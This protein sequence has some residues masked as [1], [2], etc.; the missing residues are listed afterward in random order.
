MN[1]WR[2]DTAVA[3]II[4]NR[5]DTTEKV[6][7]EIA[8]AKPSKLFVIGDGPRI[9]KP[10][11][12]NKVFAA[13][14]ITKSVDWECAVFTNFSDIN[15]GCK[16][17]VV[18]GL[19][20]VFDNVDRAIILE[21]DM[22]PHQSF[23]QYCDELLD[24]YSND[25]RIGLITGTNFIPFNHNL[26]PYSYTFT[27]FSNLP[28]WASWSRVWKSYDPDIK[29]W[30]EIRTLGLLDE[31]FYGNHPAVRYWSDVFQTAYLGSNNVWDYQLVFHLLVNNL[32][33]VVPENNMISNIGY[34]PEATNTK[35]PADKLANVPTKGISFPLV[36]P[37]YVV[38]SITR[39]KQLQ[40]NVLG[41]ASL[42][43]RL[44]RKGLRCYRFLWKR[45]WKQL[46]KELTVSR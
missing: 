12:A 37:P 15:L 20:W 8:K 30:P 13:R 46:E 2:L 7:A 17:R 3:L 26:N 36:H 10:D 39:E 44:Y 24:K 21:D 6:F 23:F 41:I 45:N 11:D 9:D 33:I 4:F 5:P 40:E 32:M 42:G 16:A 43:K 31:I 35:D 1:D 29:S 14:A 25:S 34:G 27:R 22:L 18:S 19:S 38:P 28:G